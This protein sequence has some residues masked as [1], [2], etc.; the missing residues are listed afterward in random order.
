[1]LGLN[2]KLNKI[3]VRLFGDYAQNLQGSDRANKAC[4]GARTAFVPVGEGSVA[5]ISSPQTDDNKAYMVGI[6]VG[7]LDSLGFVTGSNSK[8]HGWEV[9]T[10]WQHVELYALDPNLVDSDFFEGRLNL[11]GI[12]AAIAYGLT[13]NVVGTVR[14]G[15]ANRINDKLGTGG[16]GGDLQQMSPVDSFHLLQVDL[17]L[18][19]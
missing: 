9:R 12:Y 7:S 6:A 11:E 18:K 2:I 8:R 1:L 19:F 17:A 14:Y 5:K 16:A 15:Y 10:C 13:E 3:S 4:T